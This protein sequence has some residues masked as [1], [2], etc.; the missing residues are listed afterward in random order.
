M[1]RKGNN[2]DKR[3]E[4]IAEACCQVAKTFFKIKANEL[5]TKDI[6]DKNWKMSELVD[7]ALASVNIKVRIRFF[8]KF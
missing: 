1:R 2:F 3:D 4:K 8:T 7:N 5:I 6:E